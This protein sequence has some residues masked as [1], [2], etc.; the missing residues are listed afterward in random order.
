MNNS[1]RKENYLKELSEY[2]SGSIDILSE[3]KIKLTDEEGTEILKPARLIKD[4]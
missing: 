4:C 2:F 3:E 1:A